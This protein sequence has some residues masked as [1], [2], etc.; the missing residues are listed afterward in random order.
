MGYRLASLKRGLPPVA[1]AWGM[2]VAAV[3]QG[4][5]FRPGQP[6]QFSAPASDSVAS[7]PPSLSPR[8]PE[9][10]KFDDRIQAPDQFDFNRMSPADPFPVVAPM[11]TPMESARGRDLQERRRNWAFLTPAEILG[12]MTPEKILGISERDAFGQLRN[13]TALERYADRQNRLQARVRTNA[14]SIGNR[15]PAWIFS[16]DQSNLPDFLGN[17]PATALNPGRLLSPASPDFPGA[18]RQNENAGR[19]RLYSPSSV[20]PA[21]SPGPAAADDM[22][23]FRQLLNPWAPAP[24]PSTTPVAGGLKTSLPQS[25]LGAGLDQASATRLGTSLAP[26]SSGIGKP[27]DM[28]KLAGP[29]GLNATSAPPAAVWAPQTAPWL[30]PPPFA[31][32]QRKF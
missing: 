22:E 26:L 2:A 7:N 11:P 23:R 24:A 1:L 19:S 13:P 27:A 14:S 28:P 30:S 5:L 15:P 31:A 9:A 21:S 10:L 20:S 8:P 3:A 32:P 12:V 6:I 4:P 25:L 16:D 17:G 29:L 18:A